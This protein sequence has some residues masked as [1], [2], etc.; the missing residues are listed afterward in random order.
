MGLAICLAVLRGLLGG[1]NKDT[2][3]EGEERDLGNYYVDVTRAVVRVLIPAAAML[4]L[5]LTWQGVPSSYEGAATVTTLESA[6]VEQTI[7]RGPVAAMVAINQPFTL[8]MLHS[9]FLSI[10]KDLDESALVDGC[11]RFQAFRMV[12]MPVMWPGATCWSP[13]PAT[14]WAFT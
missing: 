5:L 13:V 3:A 8:W 4:A 9:F 6:N 2:A 14:R 10:P 1:N 7:P 11:T 12:N